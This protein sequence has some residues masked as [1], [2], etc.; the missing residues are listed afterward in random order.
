MMCVCVCV[1]ARARVRVRA[2]ACVRVRA[3]ARACARACARVCAARVCVC[4]RARVRVRARVC[5]RARARVCE[6]THAPYGLKLLRKFHNIVSIHKVNLT[7]T[8]MGIY[9]D[10]L[11]YGFKPHDFITNVNQQ[12]LA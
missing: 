11:T 7:H 1:C 6:H 12:I 8:Q 2:C 9:I 4:A 10:K 5:A 3:R